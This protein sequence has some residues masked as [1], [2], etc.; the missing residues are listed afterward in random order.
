MKVIPVQF[1]GN[2]NQCLII[3]NIG[4]DLLRCLWLTVFIERTF[5]TI[6]YRVYER[7][8]FLLVSIILVT[9]SYVVT[10]AINYMKFN[11]SKKI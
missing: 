6:Y 7:R 1:Y 3:S 4:W 8:R 10:I 11:R 2:Y 9:A 5:A